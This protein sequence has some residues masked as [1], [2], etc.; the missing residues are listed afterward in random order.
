M[1]NA[2]RESLELA[3]DEE[4][5]Q[6]THILFCRRFN[7][8]DYLHGA[9]ESEVQACDRAT[10]IDRVEQRF[11]FLAADGLTVLRGRS[12]QVSYHDVLL[13]V[14]RFL[15]IPHQA[16]MDVIELES[17]IFLNLMGRAWQK[18]PQPQ[19]R[20]LTIR[21]QG[22]LK[23]SNFAQPLPGALLHNPVPFMLKSSGVLALT[24]VVR[25][26]VLRQIAQQFTVHLAQYQLAKAAIAGGGVVAT[27][28]LQKQVALYTAKRGLALAAARQGA[29]R[30]MFAFLGP[31]LW[32][33]LA[34]D[35]GWRAIAT[36]YSRIIPTIFMLAQIRLTRTEVWVEEV[37]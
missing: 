9:D 18:L 10:Q 19:K 2:L 1:V 6:L 34:V 14:C 32:G 11:R 29:V 16:Q 33:S 15:K 27:T 26:L 36:N 30:T 5:H 22:A 23:R 8:L 37:A 3:T 4:L 25:S 21:I 7:P 28:H 20:S 35:L 13:R 31:L 24:T 17:E 12:Q